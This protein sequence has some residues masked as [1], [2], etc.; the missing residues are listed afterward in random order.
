MAGRGSLLASSK[1]GTGYPCNQHPQIA[2]F[3]RDLSLGLIITEK[4][5]EMIEDI[6]TYAMCYLFSQALDIINMTALFFV[7]LP[8]P[9]LAERDYLLNQE[10]PPSIMLESVDSRIDVFFCPYYFFFLIY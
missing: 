4:Y 7:F 6:C 1:L 8:S 10:I 5:P 3:P 9:A 2:S